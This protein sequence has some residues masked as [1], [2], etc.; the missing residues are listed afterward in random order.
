[1][2]QT[3][4]IRDP[5][6]GKDVEISNNL[7]DRL[8]GKYANGPTMPNGE[9][10]FGWR[11]FDTPPIQHE[12]AAEIDRLNEWADSFSEA[13]LK[14]RRLCEERIQEMQRQIDQITAQR[15]AA[16]LA[17]QEISLTLGGTDEWS[18]QH[19]MISDVT[20]RVREWKAEFEGVAL[21][22]RDERL[23]LMEHLSL[24]LSQWR[25]YAEVNCDVDLKTSDNAE[26]DV[27]R[28]AQD[29]LG[30]LVWVKP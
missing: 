11:Q 26:G 3:R 27:Y 18:D 7:T 29:F 6:L 8:R 14:E 15:D 17:L 9:P 25:M 23:K 24:A 1:M 10:E 5:F 19:N 16:D 4:T 12:A 28:K 21:E 2:Q 22:S 13:Q 30:G 20:R